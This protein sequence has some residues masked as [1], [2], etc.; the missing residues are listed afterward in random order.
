MT[1]ALSFFTFPFVVLM[2]DGRCL[3]FKINEIFILNLL[4]RSFTLA[5]QNHAD[6]PTSEASVARQK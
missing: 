6:G 3:N 5:N 1:K 4:V 2:V